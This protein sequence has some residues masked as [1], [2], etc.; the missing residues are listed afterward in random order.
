MKIQNFHNI[1]IIMTNIWYGGFLYNENGDD[2][3][4]DLWIK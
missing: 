1:V 4:D 3:D 2:D